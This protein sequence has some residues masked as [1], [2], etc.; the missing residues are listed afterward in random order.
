MTSTA[1]KSI[2]NKLS[3]ADNP[4]IDAKDTIVMCVAR[5]RLLDV[6]QTL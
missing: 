3:A 4:E 1:G 5:G 2:R 6:P